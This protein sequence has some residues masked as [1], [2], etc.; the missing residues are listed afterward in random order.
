[1]FENHQNLSCE[2][3]KTVQFNVIV[4]TDEL[5]IATNINNLFVK[6]IAEIVN[7]KSFAPSPHYIQPMLTSHFKFKLIDVNYLQTIVN[8]LK[9]K[10]NKYLNN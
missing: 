8:T 10:Y 7:S 4:F 2:N 1:M 5:A 9:I 6:S 3:V